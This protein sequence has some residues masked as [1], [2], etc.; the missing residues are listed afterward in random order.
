[1]NKKYSLGAIVGRFQI[2]HKG[3]AMVIEEGISQCENFAI[4]VGSSQE[5]RTE[6]NPFSFLERKAFLELA[7]PGIL[8]YPLPD[9]GVGNCGKWGDY[10]IGQVVEKCGKKPDVFFSGEEQRRMSWVDSSWGIKEVFIP[11]TIEISST[12]MKEFLLANNKQGWDEYIAKGLEPQF[13]FCREI[14]VKS[15]GNTT[16]KSL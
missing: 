15:Q 10:V 1:M 16:T 12:K 9:I 14:V 7:F 3:H 13:D 4:F 11:K 5:Q 2:L 8:V 6:K